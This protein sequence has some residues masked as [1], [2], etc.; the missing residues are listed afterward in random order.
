MREETSVKQKKA[1]KTLKDVLEGKDNFNGGEILDI[2]GYSKSMQTNPKVVF[3]SNGFKL[4]LKELGFSLE[5]ADLA[6]A[7]ILNGGKEENRLKASDQ[8]YK[9]L[10]GYSP[11]RHLSLNVTLTKEELEK[12]NEAIEQA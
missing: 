8:I 2:S 7:K 6:V 11:E 1:A 10:G 12:A 3:E 4:A 9:R 5:A